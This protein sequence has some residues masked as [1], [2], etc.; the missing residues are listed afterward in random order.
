[1]KRKQNGRPIVR[2]HYSCAKYRLNHALYAWTDV[3]V[4][5][6]GLT[7]VG[8]THAQYCMV[9]TLHNNVLLKFSKHKN[10]IK[11]LWRDYAMMWCNVLPKVTFG[12]ETCKNVKKNINQ[13]LILKTQGYWISRSINKLLE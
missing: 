10:A 3:C 12:K 8:R 11:P 2:I 6:Q 7:Y 13:L 5:V 4:C 9:T 1:M